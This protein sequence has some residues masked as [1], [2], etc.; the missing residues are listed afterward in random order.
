MSK[1][2]KKALEDTIDVW[3]KIINAHHSAVLMQRLMVD[4]MKPV[5]ESSKDI[6]R[7]KK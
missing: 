5:I 7:R 4:D 1:E 2:I 6:L 3:D